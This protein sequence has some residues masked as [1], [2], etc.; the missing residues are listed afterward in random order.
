MKHLG[1]LV[2][3]SLGPRFS[4][5]DKFV[6]VAHAGPKTILCRRLWEILYFCSTQISSALP[7]SY[8]QV[9][10]PHPLFAFPNSMYYTKNWTS[11]WYNPPSLTSLVAQM[12]KRLPTMQETWIQSLGQEDLLEKEMVTHSSTLAWKIPEMEEPGRL[13]SMALQRVEHD[14]VTSL[15]FLSPSLEDRFILK[16]SDV[17]VSFASC[18]FI[19]RLFVYC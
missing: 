12:V 3:C 13:Q 2:Q 19:S 11:I 15:S 1:I 5:S 7:G 6:V 16:T 17:V 4:I 14:W 18:P 9:T 10:F 8:W